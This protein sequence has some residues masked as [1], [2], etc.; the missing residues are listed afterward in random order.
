MDRAHE[1]GLAVGLHLGRLRGADRAARTALVVDQDLHAEL[2]ADLR[3]QRTGEDVG[4][5]A[6]RE[7]VDPGDRACGPAL[8]RAGD[9]RCRQR[10][11][12]AQ[13]EG[14]CDAR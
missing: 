7:R 3:R 11:G 14:A 4:A 8:L 13:L 10:R 5:A 1:E 2:L 6:G 9:D 12:E